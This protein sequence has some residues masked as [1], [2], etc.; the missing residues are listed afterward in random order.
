M[1]RLPRRIIRAYIQFELSGDKVC[2]YTL[3]ATKN[4]LKFVFGGTLVRLGI[5]K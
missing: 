5:F 4:V 2:G 3:P 1:K